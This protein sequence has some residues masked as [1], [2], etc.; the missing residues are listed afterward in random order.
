MNIFFQRKGSALILAIITGMVII[1]FAGSAI[2]MSAS[3]YTYSSQEMQKMKAMYIA[4]SGLARGVQYLNANFAN[5]VVSF[6]EVDKLTDKKLFENESLNAP[7][8]GNTIKVGEYTVTLKRLT[9]TDFQVPTGKDIEG[10]TTNSVRYLSLSSTGYLP[11]AAN[12]KYQVSITATYEIATQVPH[13]FDYAYF[14]NNWGW[15]Y[16]S[17]I[18]VYGNVRANGT[19]S[20]KYNPIINGKDRFES[21]VNNDFIGHIDDNGNGKQDDGGVYAWNA[22]V[23]TV[24]TKSKADLYAGLKGADTTPPV[25]Q[26][27]M[28]NINNLTL[29]ENMAKDQNSSIK[30]NGVTVCDGIQGDNETQQNLYLEGTKEAPVEINGTV[31]VR[32]DVIIRGWIKGTGTIYSGRNIYFPQRLLYVNAPGEL[33]PTINSESSRESRR[34]LW[35][36]QGCDL[37]GF[38]ARENLVLSDFTSS[39]WQSEVKAYVDDPLNNNAEDAGIDKIPNTDDEGEDDGKFTT[40][41]SPDGSI[42]PGTGEDIDGD[43]TF[44]PDVT[45]LNMMSVFGLKESLSTTNW[46][47]LPSGV[48]NFRNLTYWNEENDNPWPSINTTTSTYKV[49]DFPQLDGVFYTNHF[50][51]GYFYNSSY[52]YKNANTGYTTSSSDIVINGSMICKNEALIAGPG[53]NPKTGSYN[54]NAKF[55][56]NHDERLT[57]DDGSRFGFTLPLVWQPLKFVSLSI[58]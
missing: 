42:I 11:S 28:P 18:E 54:K 50:S 21:V 57:A 24:N 49:Q 15:I 37:V 47:N 3:D 1:S 30:I 19:F 26:E 58:K 2:Y 8:N 44:D 33:Q 55:Y 34:D 23:G 16:G 43:G 17:S 22:I 51:V 29:Y 36:K 27:P 53:Y 56:F 46:A 6:T 31:V 40:E 4:E 48:T 10:N 9:S 5:S 52:T 32:G 14:V 12:P 13:V 35:D 7:Y 25:P 20:F 41:V 45:G 39:T 38:F